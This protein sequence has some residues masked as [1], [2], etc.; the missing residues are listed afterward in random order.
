MSYVEQR[1]IELGLPYVKPVK[2]TPKAANGPKSA[3]RYTHI[4][5]HDRDLMRDLAASGMD[6]DEIAFKFE[7]SRFYVGRVLR[8]EVA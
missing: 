1:L 2:R 4:T 3:P 7:C 5:Q 8:Y 6:R